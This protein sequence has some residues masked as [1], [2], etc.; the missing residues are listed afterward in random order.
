MNSAEELRLKLLFQEDYSK[1]I[2]KGSKTTDDF[3]R[4][5]KRSFSNVESYIQRAGYALVTYWG[6][7]AA[8]SVITGIVMVGDETDR[9]QARLVGIKGGI[10]GAAASMEH[11]KKIAA[12]VPFTL[13][14]VANAGVTLEAFGADAETTLKAVSD[15]AAFMGEDLAYAAQAFGRAWSGGA[16]AARVLRNRGVL[17]EIM[18]MKPEIEDLTKFTLP[19]FRKVM[20][21]VLTDQGGRIAGSTDRLAKTLSGSW[22]MLG[23]AVYQTADNVAHSGLN[24][25]LRDIVKTAT[26]GAEAIRDF[27]KEQRKLYKASQDQET[28]L[29]RI[30]KSLQTNP[31]A[32]AIIYMGKKAKEGIKDVRQLQKLAAELEAHSGKSAIEAL[33]FKAPGDDD[34]LPEFKGDKSDEKSLEEWTEGEKKRAEAKKSVRDWYTKEVEAYNQKLL[35]LDRQLEDDLAKNKIEARFKKEEEEAKELDRKIRKEEREVERSERHIQRLWEETHSELEVLEYKYEEELRIVGLN[36]AAREMVEQK[37]A[38]KRQQIREKHHK[39]SVNSTL[40]MWNSILSIGNSM[41]AK[42]FYFEKALAAAEV[43]VNTQRSIMQAMS[44][45]H[46]PQALKIKQ[47]KAAAMMGAASLAAIA[48]SAIAGDGGGGSGGGAIGGSSEPSS[49]G[50]YNPPVEPIN[51][52]QEQR[53]GIVIEN[54]HFEG[55]TTE[56]AEERMLDFLQNELADGRVSIHPR[57]V[58]ER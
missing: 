47:A 40:S 44:Q 4:R 2:K 13:S 39:S 45:P 8:K 7:N 1:K 30:E 22:S 14:E 55:T 33:G 54:I 43:V 18:R 5:A 46:L 35:D 9:L 6:Y 38:Q 23:D 15:L 26:E 25:S 58:N 50:S 56:E 16:G 10:E 17:N 51:Q 52:P 37:Y 31:L 34:D 3:E 11:F 48:A 41:G 36:E 20:L 21:D 29:D 49:S 19:E 27:T 42:M 53:G 12:T 57:V 32:T 24:D 28:W